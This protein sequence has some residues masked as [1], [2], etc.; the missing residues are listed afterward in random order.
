MSWPTEAS[1]GAPTS[2]MTAAGSIARTTVVP[3]ST[4]TVTLHGRRT[5]TSGTAL[6]ARCADGG[7]QAPRIRYGSRS[8]SSFFFSVAWTSISVRT[9][10]PSF[11]SA[12]RARVTA[13][14][15]REGRRRLEG[16]RGIFHR[17]A[18]FAFALCEGV[19]R[20]WRAGAVAEGARRA[21]G[22]T[23]LT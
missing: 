10:K 18:P 13:F 14:V 7:W 11:A 16:D 1:S 8:T 9:P 6:R 17:E 5:P 12:S 15:E 4:D 2:P 20:D 19:G 21:P 23:T 3:F 22:I